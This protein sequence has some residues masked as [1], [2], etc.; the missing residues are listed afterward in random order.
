MVK[1]RGK[2]GWARSAR[3]PWQ[4]PEYVTSTFAQT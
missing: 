1:G 4:A 2:M 3:A